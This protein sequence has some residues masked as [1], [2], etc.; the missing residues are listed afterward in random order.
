MFLHHSIFPNFTQHQPWIFDLNLI[1]KQSR[2]LIFPNSGPLPPKVINADGPPWFVHDILY[3]DTRLETHIGYFHCN[4]FPPNCTS[5]V[6]VFIYDN[7]EIISSLQKKII[8]HYFICIRCYLIQLQNWSL[9]FY[10]NCKNIYIKLLL[11]HL[12]KL[13]INFKSQK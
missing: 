1:P 7:K 11:W 9:N 2:K 4:L 10:L 13:K 3:L 6:S 5:S 12:L 8:S